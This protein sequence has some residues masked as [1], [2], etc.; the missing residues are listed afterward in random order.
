MFMAILMFG[1]EGTEIIYPDPGFPIYRSMIEFTGATPVPAPCAKKRLRLLGRGDAGLIT[2][3]TRLLILNSPANPTG[4]VTP[5]RRSTA[6][7]RDSPP[8]GRRDPVRRDLRPAHLRRARPP[9]AARLSRDPRPADPAG[10]LVEDL[11]DDRL[12]A[13]L[14][15]VAEALARGG[16]KARGEFLFLRQS[17]A[18]F[19]GVAALRGPR[20]RS[21]RCGRSST[22]AAGVVAG[23]IRLPGVSAVPPKGAFYAFRISQRP[24]GRRA[25]V[26]A[27]EEAG[28]ATLGGPAFGHGEGYLRLSYANSLETSSS[29]WRDGGASR[30]PASV[31][32]R[33]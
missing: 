27:A 30:R 22:A 14:F 4:G 31:N 24:A 1:E 28:V 23:L 3:K 13:R 7:S 32:A 19:A 33:G 10:R 8:S 11:R 25:G 20:I 29:R 26:R 12:A 21:R 2:P 5:P 15:G 16:A 9:I 18:Q 17:A 6:W